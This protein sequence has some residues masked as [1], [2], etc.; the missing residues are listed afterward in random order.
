MTGMS[1][2]PIFLVG[3]PRSGT[4]LL[5]T[6]LHAHPNIG[7][8]PETR[9]LLPAY[10]GREQFGN[11]DE[12]AS[13]RAVGEFIT[14]PET[15]FKDLKLDRGRVIDAVVAAPPTL[16][17]AFATVWR[18]FA[19]DRG[20][21]RWGEKRPA[22]W[23]DMDVILRLFPTAQVIHLVRDPRAVVASLQAVPWYHRA[24]HD[25]TALWVVVD[26]EL[27]RLGRRLGPDSYHR[28]RYEDLLAD[29]RQQ[30]TALCD[31]L[32]ED[33]DERMLDHVDAAGDIVPSRKTWHTR[34]HQPLD[35][36]RIDAWQR[37]LTPAQSGLIE[38]MGRLAMYRNGY[39][40]SD[41]SGRPDPSGVAGFVRR[42]V[43]LRGVMTRRRLVDARLRR[44]FPMRLESVV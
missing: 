44:R 20:A 42:A 32:G 35:P 29:P 40:S 11:L 17:S 19:H 30:L 36:S 9:F 10:R 24:S 7:M 25:A 8:P 31:Y 38:V 15:N 43:E 18:E 34:V 12:P 23:Q 22:Y 1:S 27:R 5:S 2:R 26:S 28:L 39:R 37:S 41:I 21:T 3:C 6:I 4:T 33:F 13:R 14:G 16:G